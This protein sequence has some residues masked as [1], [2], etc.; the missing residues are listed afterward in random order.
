[1]SWTEIGWR[2]HGRSEGRICCVVGI[3]LCSH[4]Q[5]TTHNTSNNQ[6]GHAMQMVYLPAIRALATAYVRRASPSPTRQ[7]SS[8]SMCLGDS[9]QVKPV[10]NKTA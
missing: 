1:M 5:H 2:N 8:T 10:G 7:T 6:T 9:A 4:T 3:M